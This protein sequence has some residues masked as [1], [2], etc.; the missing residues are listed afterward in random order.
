MSIYVRHNG[1]S[2]GMTMGIYS[3]SAGNQYIPGSL[4]RDTAGFTVSNSSL[5]WLTHD[6]DSSLAVTSGTVYH[7]AQHSDGNIYR[8]RYDGTAG[9]YRNYHSASYTAG[10]LPATYSPALTQEYYRHSIYATY[11]LAGWT[12]KIHGLSNASIGKIHGLAKASI[13]KV[14]GT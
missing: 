7:L 11:E 4:L 2:T 8:L 9:Y 10:S 13:A 6:L 5:D 3:R 1:T 14:L 12:H